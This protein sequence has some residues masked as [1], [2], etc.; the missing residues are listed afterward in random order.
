MSNEVWRYRSEARGHA[1]ELI[2][3]GHERL[4]DMKLLREY[5]LKDSTNFNK[6]IS[7]NRHVAESFLIATPSR[8]LSLLKQKNIKDDVL[9]QMAVVLGAYQLAR[10]SVIAYSWL[11]N[12]DNRF[13]A[14]D[15]YRVATVN[16]SRLYDNLADMPKFSK[17]PLQWG[18]SPFKGEKRRTDAYDAEDYD[19]VL[20][21]FDPIPRRH[22]VGFPT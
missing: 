3:L 2:T 22:P 14:G 4:Q 19:E 17:W 10:K 9:T 16:Q 15:A 5:I 12:H 7:E 8:R 21:D 18:T 1:V 6:W 13:R 20:D 11:M